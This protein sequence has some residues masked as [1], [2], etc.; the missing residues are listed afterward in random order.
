[1]QQYQSIHSQIALWRWFSLLFGWIHAILHAPSLW[2]ARRHLGCKYV[3]PNNHGISRH[4]TTNGHTW[5]HWPCYQKHDGNYQNA[6]WFDPSLVPPVDYSGF[7]R[8][9]K[10]I[11]H[12]IWI[13]DDIWIQMETNGCMMYTNGI[14][15]PPTNV[16]RR[17]TSPNPTSGSWKWWSH[18]LKAWRSF[19]AFSMEFV[20]VS[21][22]S[23][24]KLFFVDEQTWRVD[25]V[26]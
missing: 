4:S 24:K 14:R 16:D 9:A 6:W 2:C 22:K 7:W 23:A 1:M 11:D 10:G 26:G 12:R 8:C 17:L 19:E 3:Q 15:S 21:S 13:N 5:R 25:F 20:L 18:L